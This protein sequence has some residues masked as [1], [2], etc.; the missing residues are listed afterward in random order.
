VNLVRTLLL[1][2]ACSFALSLASAGCKPNTPDGTTPPGDGGGA[3]TDGGG[4]G[5]DGGSGAGGDGGGAEGGGDGGGDGGGAPPPENCEAK[6]A[7]AP[8][9]LF[10]EQVLIRP[11]VG[12]EFQAED[13]PTF[14]Q[15]SSSAGFVSAC[16]ATVKRVLVF[17]F[18]NDKKT[19][20][21]KTAGEFLTTLEQQGYQGGKK[22]EPTVN[23]K[24]DYHVVV[25]YPA[26]GGNQASNLYVAVARRYENVFV[27]VYEAEPA[28]FKA[29][30]PT[31]KAS[32]ESL[33]VIP[34][35][36]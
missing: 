28:D 13:N 32:A 8:T 20:L 5:D 34:P 3:A 26:A 29:L 10:G 19:G 17:V 6:T 31:F 15:A 9:P 12:V 22:G 18:Q 11:P 24:T 21:D 25:E 36:G 23:S 33:L 14:A 35:G 2:S 27:V 7:D 16:D 30:L 1:T 4:G